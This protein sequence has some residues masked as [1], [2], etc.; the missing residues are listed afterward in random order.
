MPKLNQILAI[1]KQ[2]KTQVHKEVTEIHR[3][4]QNVNF[5]TGHVKTYAPKDADGEMFPPENRKVQVLHQHALEALGKKVEEIIDLTATKDY[6]NC[7]AKA[8]VVVDGEVFIEGAPVS[9]LLFMEKQLTDLFTL[10]GKM[11]ELDPSLD[12]VLDENS[13]QYRSG[14]VTT[15][16]TKKLQR[17]IVLY[18]ATEHHPAQ[19]Q[20][21]TEDA[22]IGHWTTTSYSGAIPQPKKRALLQRIAKLHEAV[23]FAREEAN[24]IEV[25][26]KNGLGAKVIAFV[27]GGDDT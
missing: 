7:E 23:K 22:V 4:T 2:R 26:K 8:N 1:E 16:K 6:T 27:M 24:G 18:A 25:T 20:L 13:G 15:H 14:S 5:M 12:W 21:I 10:V 9:F 11:V 19:T 3:I 17:P